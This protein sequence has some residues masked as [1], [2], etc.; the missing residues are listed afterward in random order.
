[1]SIPNQQYLDRLAEISKELGKDERLP[2]ASRQLF[3]KA[4]DLADA[5][6]YDSTTGDCDPLEQTFDLLCEACKTAGLHRCKE[7][8]N[9]FLACQLVWNY[10]A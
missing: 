5:H 9:G 1:M 7:G 8:Q 3:S 4:L 2:D 10:S 6:R